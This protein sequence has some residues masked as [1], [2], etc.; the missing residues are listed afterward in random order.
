MMLHYNKSKFATTGAE[1]IFF[2]AYFILF[3]IGSS[4]EY[5]FFEG[6]S[7]VMFL[8]EIP[9][10]LVYGTL[11][12]LPFWIYYKVLVQQCLFNRRFL[13]FFLLL[14]VFLFLL[15]LYTVFGYWLIPHFRFLPEKMISNAAKWYKANTL[16][17]FSVVYIFRDMLVITSLA[18]YLRSTR[19]TRQLEE[20][21]RQQ[22]ETEL[23]FLKV[24][25]Q[26][27]FFFNTLNNI[28]ALALQR[29]D[30][31]ADLVAKHTEMMRYI[32]YDS[33]S[34]QLGLVQEIDFIS[35]Y[36]TVESVRFSENMDIQFETQGIHSAF[37]IEPLLLLPF[38]EN[39]F[40]HGARQEI[41]SGYIHVIICLLENELI[42]EA[43]NSKPAVQADADGRG[44]G[45]VNASK[46]LALLYP[47]SHQI[48]ITQDHSHYEVRLSILL[49]SK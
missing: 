21:Q 26:P 16:V 17:H 18:Y 47:Q 24:Q 33:T 38:I 25:L 4:F 8:R 7:A 36:I 14:I 15:N 40:K 23:K 19:L 3:P 2:L 12:M 27:H 35:N 20:L 29:S 34:A 49:R 37:N 39:T 32:L 46:R 45:L 44:I 5:N 22:L 42:M 48:N 28:Y 43:K 13:A 1:V 11:N 41:G 30:K 6:N 9:E 31:T 10:R